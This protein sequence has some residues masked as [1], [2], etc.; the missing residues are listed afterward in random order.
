MKM[1]P[2]QKRTWAEVHLYS[3]QYNFD[4]IRKAVSTAKICCVIKANGY[5]HGAV[6]LAQL[7][8]EYGADFLGVSNIEEALQLRAANI[9]LP[10]LILGYTDPECAEI[11]AQ[12]DI[13]QCVFSKD[14]AEALS[15]NG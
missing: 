14:Y 8:Q 3:L 9:R 5:G 1:W 15:Q 11:L 4:V 12:Q 7:Y 2:Y 10:I 6:Y 13:S